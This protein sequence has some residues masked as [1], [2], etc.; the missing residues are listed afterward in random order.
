MSEVYPRPTLAR[1][2]SST[3][4]APDDTVA[5]ATGAPLSLARLSGGYIPLPAN[6]V[7]AAQSSDARRSLDELYRD[8]DDYLMQYEKATAKLIAE[9]YLLAGFKRDYMNIAAQNSALFDE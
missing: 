1:E 6:A 9:G 3:V 7:A 4:I 2:V 8:F 5:V